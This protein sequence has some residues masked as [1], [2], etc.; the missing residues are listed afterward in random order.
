MTAP[1]DN[2]EFY[3]KPT[4]VFRLDDIL[5]ESRAEYPEPEP[6]PVDYPKGVTPPLSPEAEEILFQKSI[7]IKEY[8]EA[9]YRA[10]D[11]AFEDMGEYNH[12]PGWIPF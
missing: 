7:E 2:N 5:G 11:Q 3:P 10:I 4:Y 8:L 12:P 6:L 9:A 1:E